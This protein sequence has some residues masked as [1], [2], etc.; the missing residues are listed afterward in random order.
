MSTNFEQWKALAALI[1]KERDPEKL[2]Q[3]AHEM[4]L[5]LTQ[6]MRFES[7]R[8]RKLAA[9]DSIEVGR[10]HNAMPVQVHR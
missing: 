9:S 2:T 7:H 3:L 5:V 8:D 6:K 1:S 4:N 10:S